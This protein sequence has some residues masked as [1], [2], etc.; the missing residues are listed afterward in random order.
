MM[1]FRTVLFLL[2]CSLV[3]SCNIE[4]DILGDG[5]A[6]TESNLNS[7]TQ[8]VNPTLLDSFN[9]DNS[10]ATNVVTK[11]YMNSRKD[12]IY[13][14]SAIDS[15]GQDFSL[16][17]TSL[18]SG[19]SFSTTN[20]F[21]LSAGATW[22]KTFGYAEDPAGRLFSIHG[23][24]DA[25]GNRNAVIK[26]SLDNGLTWAI[27]DTY[28]SNVNRH[29]Y[30]TGITIDDNGDIYVVGQT[31]NTS[32]FY[33]GVMRRSVDGGASWS[34]IDLFYPIAGR[35]TGNGRVLIS[36]GQ[37]YLL[38][39][40]IGADSRYEMLLR[41]S[42]NNGVSWTIESTYKAEPGFHTVPLEM[43][44][45][46]QGHLLVTGS[47]HGGVGFTNRRGFVLKSEDQGQ[48]WTRLYYS[49]YA[50]NKDNSVQAIRVD[51]D[52]NIYF[53]GYEVD[54]TDQQYAFVKMLE[55]G[56]NTSS[57]VVRYQYETGYET[58]FNGLQFIDGEM[59]VTGLFETSSATSISGLIKFTCI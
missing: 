9:L 48:T 54:G 20:Q 31:M 49:D 52:N 21:Q 34:T 36:G 22:S 13:G 38:S 55:S 58:R 51:S 10:M 17:R 47:T 33:Q 43:I 46:S 23:L 14:G 50:V 28:Q 37:I 40:M 5:R 18:D 6:K 1:I 15:G 25:T 42:I 11:F 4:F 35:H 7:C 16:T 12:I 53:T 8:V 45:N 27:V 44:I 57:Y 56:N 24:E 30:Y 2:I 39:F 26:R 19:S 3:T 59:F 29:S 41:K 32:N